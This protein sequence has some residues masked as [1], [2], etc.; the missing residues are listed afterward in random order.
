VEF[1]RPAYLIVLVARI[2]SHARQRE[3]AYWP[4]PP[5]ILA[6]T[7]TSSSGI[8]EW[9]ASPSE[10]E[11]FITND[12]DEFEVTDLTFFSYHTL[13]QRNPDN[14]RY[15]N[16]FSYAEL[17][18]TVSS[19]VLRP[20][21]SVRRHHLDPNLDLSPLHK[22]I[23]EVWL[24][25]CS[26]RL[27]VALHDWTASF[28]AA[29]CRRYLCCNSG[30][31]PTVYEDDPRAHPALHICLDAREVEDSLHK[32]RLDHSNKRCPTLGRLHT[33]ERSPATSDANS[34]FISI[35]SYTRSCQKIGRYHLDT[36]IPSRLLDFPPAHAAG[37][38][39]WPHFI[40]VSSLPRCPPP[41]SPGYFA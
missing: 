21:P 18:G 2:V 24:P 10:D 16:Y 26:F 7:R 23:P 6:G 17:Y 13:E 5:E 37:S 12:L 14:E 38:Q 20:E 40:V 22:F 4:A 3:Y 19:P 30:S 9:G 11:I 39:A 41:R 32:R 1:E 33:C 34:F 27:T 8:K 15:E 25:S 35:Q 36:H 29:T 28:L 31:H